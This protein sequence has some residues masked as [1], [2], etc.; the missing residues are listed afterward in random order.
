MDE[1]R[2]KSKGGNCIVG[3]TVLPGSGHH[4]IV[5]RQQLDEI[6]PRLDG[7]VD[8]LPEVVE[9]TYAEAV[10]SAQRKD[11]DGRPGAPPGNRAQP[12]NYVVDNQRHTL[13]RDYAAVMVLSFLPAENL[14]R[15]AIYDEVFIL[16]RFPGLNSG[17]PVWETA[18]IQDDKLFPIAKGGSA[19]GKGQRLFRPYL[20]SDGAKDDITVGRLRFCLFPAENHVPESRGPE[21]RIRGPV[22]PTVADNRLTRPQGEPQAVAPPLRA[23]SLSLADQFIAILPSVPDFAAGKAGLPASV[24]AVMHFESMLPDPEDKL[25]APYG[26]VLKRKMNG[27][28]LVS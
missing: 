17:L 16:E 20:R 28:S 3:I 27:H 23:D 10:G 18:V 11:G 2:M 5:D 6:L 24:A 22:H 9:L 14:P 21:G 15:F 4:S 19:A 12:G 8:H 1:L 7:P 25:L 13:W 26:P